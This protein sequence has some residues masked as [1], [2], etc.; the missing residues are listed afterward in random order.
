M[1]TQWKKSTI[2]GYC[3]SQRRRETI[4]VQSNDAMEAQ[5]S[6]T[7]SVTFGQGGS[8]IHRVRICESLHPCQLLADH[9]L[10][11]SADDHQPTFRVNND[12]PVFVVVTYE[13]LRRGQE[14]QGIRGIRFQ[15]S[16]TNSRI[17]SLPGDDNEVVATTRG[18]CII[19]TSCK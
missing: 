6:Q 11:C 4:E 5:V 15:G 18:I 2:S 3:W 16:A 7:L 14:R 12:L 13:R 19:I 1:S 9:C 17:S 10:R 8:H